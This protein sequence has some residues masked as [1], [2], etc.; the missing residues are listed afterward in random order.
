[1]MVTVFDPNH[2]HLVFVVPDITALFLGGSMF[3]IR[4]P[5]GNGRLIGPVRDGNFP[6]TLA[7]GHEIQTAAPFHGDPPQTLRRFGI[8]GIQSLRPGAEDYGI[9]STQASERNR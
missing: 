3:R 1:M 6:I 8:G 4:F 7:Y 2:V 9:Q 5:G